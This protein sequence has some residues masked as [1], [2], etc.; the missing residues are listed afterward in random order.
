MPFSPN[1]QRS[2]QKGGRRSRPSSPT[3]GRVCCGASTAAPQS[4]RYAVPRLEPPSSPAFTQRS[5]RKDTSLRIH[6]LSAAIRA[7]TRATISSTSMDVSSARYLPPTI[8][9]GNRTRTFSPST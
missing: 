8:M 1:A 9:P 2:Q 5:G 6:L 7:M 3:H 4:I